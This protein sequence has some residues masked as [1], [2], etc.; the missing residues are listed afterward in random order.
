MNKWQK[1]LE[2]PERK[3]LI[4]DKSIFDFGKLSQH[5]SCILQRGTG[6]RLE[7]KKKPQL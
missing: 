2:S 5:Q 4:E 7:N 3:A 6:F 1:W